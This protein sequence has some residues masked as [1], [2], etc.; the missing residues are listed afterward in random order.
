ML[1]C[2]KTKQA[3]SVLHSQFRNRTVEKEYL[4]VVRGGQD[5]FTETD[6]ILQDHLRIN[7][8]FV[9]V[10]KQPDDGDRLAVTS[11]KLL[12]SSVRLTSTH[13]SNMTRSHAVISHQHL[14]H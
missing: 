3:L 12:G 14:F 4:A 6:G 10:V 1:I 11:W 5:A 7:D 2:G 13:L 9:S 8:G